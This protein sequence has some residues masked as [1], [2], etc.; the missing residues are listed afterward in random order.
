MDIPVAPLLPSSRA[1]L[2]ALGDFADWERRYDVDTSSLV[3]AAMGVATFWDQK[4]HDSYTKDQLLAM[5]REQ[6]NR[7]LAEAERLGRGGKWQEHIS[8]CLEKSGVGIAIWSVEVA[9][10]NT[11]VAHSEKFQKL[12]IQPGNHN[13]ARI[14]S[15]LGQWKDKLPCGEGRVGLRSRNCDLLVMDGDQHPLVGALLLGSWETAEMLW[16]SMGKSIAKNKPLINDCLWAVLSYLN[17][18]R[19]RIDDFSVM[20]TSR[21]LKAGADTNLTRQGLSHPYIHQGRTLIFAPVNGL[22]PP[23]DKKR[24]MEEMGWD[25]TFIHHCETH[26]KL[27]L[28]APYEFEVCPNDIVLANI[29]RMPCG[30]AGRKWVDV[31]A[32]HWKKNPPRTALPMYGNALDAFLWHFVNED[33]Q[34]IVVNG[35]VPAV[36]NEVKRKR[37]EEGVALLNRIAEKL[38]PILAKANPWW[39]QDSDLVGW[40][41]L[42]TAVM[43]MSNKWHESVGI[44]IVKTLLDSIPQGQ[45]LNEKLLSKIVQG[46]MIGKKFKICAS[47]DYSNGGAGR[48]TKQTLDLGAR[49]LRQTLELAISKCRPERQ[50]RL[51]E[52]M[53]ILLGMVARAEQE[54][55]KEWEER[56]ASSN[57]MPSTSMDSDLGKVWKTKLMLAGQ[58]LGELQKLD[59]PKP[60]PKM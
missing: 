30:S 46:N 25:F 43:T 19:S 48:Q 28:K 22:S 52:G 45:H 38:I 40:S 50:E 60:T 5:A 56:G 33:G 47:V 11:D 49:K 58:R 2:A 7:L 36:N 54:I 24:S 44:E 31:W 9:L 12:A 51:F 35:G 34:K 57:V 1:W 21:L 37:R 17:Q 39:E 4:K 32:R 13:L 59:E 26:P 41:A 15:S 53:N 14:V 20:W 16:T 6:G 55:T 27:A 10:G 23:P 18:E 3:M 8:S 42:E 29:L